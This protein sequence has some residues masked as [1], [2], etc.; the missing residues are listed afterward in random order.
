MTVQEL[1]QSETAG[2]HGLMR[3]NTPFLQHP[4]FNK[5][6][7]ETDMQRY[8]RLLEQ[9]DLSLTHSM[10]PLGSCTMKLNAATEMMP[11]TWPEFGKLHPFAPIE[12]AQGYHK[13][14][15]QLENWLAEM[16]G[17]AAISLQ[18]NAGAQGEYTGLLVISAYHYYNGDEKRD[19]CLIPSSAHGTNPSSA[20]MAGMRV[21]I[22]RCDDRGNIDIKDLRAKAEEYSDY[23]AAFMVT[24]PSTHGV[25]EEGIKEI[26][27]IVHENGGQVYMDG[28]N[29]NA[30]LGLCRP[31]EFGADVCHLNLHKTFCIPHGGGGPGMG[32]IGVAKHL[33]PFLPSTSNTTK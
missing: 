29:L 19:I 3:R 5:Y 20:V 26:C 27:S 18:P 14:F 6:H 16:T 9:K 1:S 12:Q 4:V 22:V 15:K 11:I 2:Y 13:I 8:I 30:Q 23:L 21:I 10:I 7:S 24:Y 31:A 28:A 25:F 17:F 32:P 33:T